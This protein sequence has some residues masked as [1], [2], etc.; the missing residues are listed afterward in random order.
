MAPRVGARALTGDAEIIA[1]VVAP[2][3]AVDEQDHLRRV[4]VEQADVRRIEPRRSQRPYHHPLECPRRYPRHPG[5]M[6]RRRFAVFEPHAFHFAAGGIDLARRIQ[7][8][9][10][11]A[12]GKF[13]NVLGGD[14]QREPGNPC[15][16]HQLACRE[17]LALRRPAQSWH[18]R[19]CFEIGKPLHADRQRAQSQQPRQLLGQIGDCLRIQRWARCD[20]RCVVHWDGLLGATKFGRHRGTTSDRREAAGTLG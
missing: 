2:L 16:R 15:L 14:A 5:L 7:S 4:A 3:Q 9:H 20:V 12:T 11:A 1:L 10:T 13:G 8:E 19:H 6:R 17:R 18:V